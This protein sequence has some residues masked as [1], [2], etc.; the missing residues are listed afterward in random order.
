MENVR[1]ILL[2]LV[3]VILF[4][5]IKIW[6]SKDGYQQMSVLQ[7]SVDTQ[8]KNNIFLED[9]NKA[10]EVEIR[11]L[12]I[13]TEAIEERARKDLGLIG[14]DEIMYIIIDQN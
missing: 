12:K 13:G 8:I 5:Q 7:N 10:L 2:L 3:I 9:R 11:D 14:K 1:W 6:V 4:M